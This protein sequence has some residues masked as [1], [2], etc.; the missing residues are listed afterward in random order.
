LLLDVGHCV[1]NLGGAG[2]WY[3]G[4]AELRGIL[5]CSSDAET[6]AAQS[7]IMMADGGDWD[8][9]EWLENAASVRLQADGDLEGKRRPKRMRSVRVRKVKMLV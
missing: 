6:W 8:G 1:V 9:S 3:R 7:V 4:G 2:T 5:V